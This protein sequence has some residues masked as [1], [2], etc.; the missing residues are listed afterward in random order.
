MLLAV[1]LPCPPGNHGG[2]ERLQ[3]VGVEIPRT[4]TQGRGGYPGRGPYKEVPSGEDGSLTNIGYQQ[5][6]SST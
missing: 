6:I 4:C 1:A 3:P 5:P 2:V